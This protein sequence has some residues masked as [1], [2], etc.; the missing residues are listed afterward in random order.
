MPSQQTATA[1]N[2]TRKLTPKEI[3]DLVTEGTK[4]ASALDGLGPMVKRL[5]EIEDL[6]RAAAEFVH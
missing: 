1:E 5:D 4:L 2:V 3:R 6:L